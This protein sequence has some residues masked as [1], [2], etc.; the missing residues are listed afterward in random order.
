MSSFFFCFSFFGGWVGTGGAFP[1]GRSS[2]KMGAN[3]SAGHGGSVLQVPEPENLPK[4]RKHRKTSTD[5]SENYRAF[6]NLELPR[7]NISANS[8]YPLLWN[9]EMENKFKMSYTADLDL[10]QG[11]KED[12]SNSLGGI[13]E[14][15]K[16]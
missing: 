9:S 3:R 6:K 16:R 11:F 2:T 5:K 7:L 8:E 13:N 12:A 4:I 14:T 1:T 10:Y 15:K